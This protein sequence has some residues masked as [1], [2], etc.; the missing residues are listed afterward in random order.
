M[1]GSITLTELYFFQIT[2][3]FEI[4]SNNSFICLEYEGQFIL[5]SHVLSFDSFIYLMLQRF[6]SF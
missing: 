6:V 4:G 3:H 5:E 1:S 2:G